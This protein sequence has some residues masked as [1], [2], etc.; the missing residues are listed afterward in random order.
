MQFLI[1]LTPWLVGLISA[2]LC[3][4]APPTVVTIK[5]APP[6]IMPPAEVQTIQ[7]GSRLICI[8]SIQDFFVPQTTRVKD[9]Q[10]RS[11]RQLARYLK[12]YSRHH[13]VHYP[14]KVSGFTG[15]IQTQADRVAL[16]QQYAEVVASFLWDFGFS[17]HELEVKGYGAAHPIANYRTPAGNLFNNRI[18]IQVN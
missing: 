15:T 5:P 10:I 8:L 12:D 16:S 1:R 4:C 13:H 14:I 3:A 2:V 11:L 7:Q 9:T 18:V 6:V 17:R